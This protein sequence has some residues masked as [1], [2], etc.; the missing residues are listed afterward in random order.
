M[1]KKNVCILI[2]AFFVSFILNAKSLIASDWITLDFDSTMVNYLSSLK[3][4]ERIEQCRDWIKLAVIESKNLPDK[5][6]LEILFDYNPLRYGFLDELSEYEYGDYR[7][8][9][10]NDTAYVMMPENTAFSKAY[11]VRVADDYRMLKGEKPKAVKIYY[12][13][14]IPENNY[15]TRYFYSGMVNSVELYSDEYG[16]IQQTIY[17]ENSLET[18]LNN[19]DDLVFAKNASQGIVLGGRKYENLNCRNVTIEDVAVLYQADN[20][21]KEQYL[22]RIGKRGL[23]S[24]YL[25]EKYFIQEQLD[26]GQSIY[27]AYTEYQQLLSE[28]KSEIRRVQNEISDYSFVDR[29]KARTYISDLRESVMALEESIKILTGLLNYSNYYKYN[30]DKHIPSEDEINIGFSLDPTVKYKQLSQE[31]LRIISDSIYFEEWYKK[32]IYYQD[33]KQIILEIKQQKEDHKNSD[34]LSENSD[35]IWTYEASLNTLIHGIDTAK[36]EEAD[37]SSRFQDVYN[38]TDEEIEADIV[39]MKSRLYSSIQKNTGVLKS[40]ANQIQDSKNLKD[41]EKMSLFYLLNGYCNNILTFDFGIDYVSNEE[42]T[43]EEKIIYKKIVRDV[44][45]A[46]NQLDYL[47][48]SSLVFNSNLEQAIDEYKGDKNI[49]TNG[50]IDNALFESLLDGYFS[51]I[52]YFQ[53]TRHLGSFLFDIKALNSY[54]KGR[55]DGYLQGTE[56]AMTLFYTDLLMKLWSFDYKNTAPQMISGFYPETNYKIA[57]THYKAEILNSSTRS[58]LAFND[59]AVRHHSNEIYFSHISTKIYNASSN[60]LKPGEEVEANYSS[61][62][63]ANWWNRNY[64]VVANYE[65]EFLRLNQIQKWTHLSFW[66]KNIGKLSWLDNSSQVHTRDLE[67][68]KWYYNND[69]T[70]LKPPIAFL[71][72]QDLNEKTECL[73]IINS[74]PFMGY[75]NSYMIGRFSGGVSLPNKS[76]FLAKAKTSIPPWLKKSLVNRRG[77]KPVKPNTYQTTKGRVYSLNKNANKVTCTNDRIFEFPSDE[78]KIFKLNLEKEITNGGITQKSGHIHLGQLKI[79]NSKSNLFKLSLT[80]SEIV[81]TRNC[82]MDIAQNNS[83]YSNKQIEK[84]FK[85]SNS[86]DFVIKLKGKDNYIKVQEKKIPIGHE[87]APISN[88]THIRIATDSKNYYDAQILSKSEFINLKRNF[89]NIKIKY[90]WTRSEVEFTNDLIPNGKKIKFDVEN[91]TIETVKTEEAWF[92]KNEINDAVEDVVWNLRNSDDFIRNQGDD[93][94]GILIN[95]DRSYMHFGKESISSNNLKAVQESTT[96]LKNEVDFIVFNDKNEIHFVNNRILT[97]PKPERLT[98]T[99]KLVLN[100]M[101][102]KIREDVRYK[103]LWIK[104]KLDS[105][106][107]DIIDQVK[108]E[109]YSLSESYYSFKKTNNIKKSEALLDYTCNSK[110]GQYIFKNHNSELPQIKTLQSKQNK[111]VNELAKEIEALRTSKDISSKEMKKIFEKNGSEIYSVLEDIVSETQATNIITRG[112]KTNTQLIYTYFGGKRVKFYKDEESDVAQSLS[113]FYKNIPLDFKHSAFVSTVS[114]KDDEYPEIKNLFSDIS[115]TGI[116][117]KDEL[118]SYDFINLMNN[119]SLK[120]IYLV[121]RTNEKGVIFSDQLVE[122]DRLQF[123]LDYDWE[124][125]SQKDFVYIITNEKEKLESILSKTKRCNYIFSSSYTIA[126]N[127]SFETSLGI[128]S[129]FISPYIKQDVFTIKTKK[130]EKYLKDNNYKVSILNS[131]KKE[132]K[133]SKIYFNKLTET[134]R[135]SIPPKIKNKLFRRGNTYKPKEVKNLLYQIKDRKIDEFKKEPIHFKSRFNSIPSLKCEIQFEM[136]N[137][138]SC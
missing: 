79:E 126:D 33:R 23:Y 64:D 101:G 31:I 59:D 97:I 125:S 111:S 70:K 43:S 21:I 58:W 78:A 14:I 110:S 89:D 90:G 114:L 20:N 4:S 92:V 26:D 29:M 69:K 87:D 133:I 116:Q 74:N 128:M 39:F 44:A 34:F 28:Y 13:N 103:E 104:N 108:P 99:N 9:I 66:L 95:N 17:D 6:N 65:P 62:R 100:R 40:I 3:E 37:I 5:E 127:I 1:S 123:L 137:V 46:L 48:D 119:D 19:S 68:D 138:V 98:E 131:V 55:Y 77:L 54:Q 86:D 109:N 2:F 84:V 45:Y 51:G 122:Y 107:L 73:S 130:L 120:Q 50:K 61:K 83:L 135:N 22:E 35:N 113:N 81:E 132:G 56:V 24:E 63:F 67:F 32:N 57:L 27:E 15:L 36:N 136:K 75:T 105:K 121:L 30:L 118:D 129:E 102:K 10:Y 16:Y 71:S 85:F 96:N 12:Y 8:F 41:W 25:N 53:D 72:S 124:S 134:E 82:L 52:L 49:G 94:S 93:I 88:N 60:D 11:V 117:T 76:T 112:D 80:E 106:D 42:H 47:K 7:Y 18:F 115:G 91:K 38:I